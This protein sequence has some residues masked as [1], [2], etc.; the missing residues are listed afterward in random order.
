MNKLLIIAL[1]GIVIIS[2]QSTDQDSV[3]ETL[4]AIRPESSAQPTGESPPFY[5]YQNTFQAL[6]QQID[7]LK[8]V[9]SIYERTNA[10]PPVDK[11]L[12]ELIPIPEN[13]QRIILQNGTVV[14]GTITGESPS[15]ISLQTSLGRLVIRKNLV[16]RVDE[17]YG[18]SAE[19]EI[20]GE[21]QIT[22]YPDREVV[23]GQVKNTG[24]KRADFVR[25]IADLWTSTT[26][27]AGQDSAFVKS[28]L[29]KYE[30]GVI[31]DTALD[32]GQIATFKVIVAINPG[33]EVEYRT[34][35]VRWTETK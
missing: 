31:T 32:P 20:I 12:L 34:Q 7:S 24:Q 21:P 17:N 1:A 15:E 35:A 5:D 3:G 28:K 10:L 25:V 33:T 30:S 4:P 6:Q 16:V 11:K 27:S 23:T 19:V 26:T 13:Q 22:V 29:M 14:V 2:A 9:V 18:V 8:T